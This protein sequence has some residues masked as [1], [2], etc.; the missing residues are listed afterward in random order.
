MIFDGYQALDLA[1]PYDVFAE[2][3]YECLIIAPRAGP[4]RSNMGLPVLAAG[5]ADADPASTDTLMVVGDSGVIAARAKR[6]LVEWI[7][8]AAA[9]RSG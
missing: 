4:V 9:P 5:I 6:E 2:A 7:G 3:G 1:G 8:A